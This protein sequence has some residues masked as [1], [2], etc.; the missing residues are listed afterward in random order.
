[1]KNS[2]EWLSGTRIAGSVLVSFVAFD[3]NLA[4]SAVA[5]SGFPRLVSIRCGYDGT[6]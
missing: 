2:L 4:G 3:E 1:M 6:T 5:G